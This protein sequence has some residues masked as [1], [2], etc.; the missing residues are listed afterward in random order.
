MVEP[1]P[2]IFIF[3]A[4]CLAAL[5]TL[6]A[7]PPVAQPPIAQ[8]PSTAD[9][10]WLAGDWV[11]RMGDGVIEEIWAPPAAGTLV[12]MFRWSTEE[13]VRLYELMTIEDG[14]QGPV[15]YLR[16]F[17]PGLLAWESKDSPMALELDAYGDRR[18]S[19]IDTADGGSTRL[20]YERTGGGLEVTL[21]KIEGAEKASTRFVYQAR[22]R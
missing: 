19:F 5:P 14:D 17:S 4:L 20:T 21:D 16:H 8:P 13:G 3:I 7:Q 9:F 18:A 15:L 1:T 10:D 12:G 11:G 2:R 6:L 22:P